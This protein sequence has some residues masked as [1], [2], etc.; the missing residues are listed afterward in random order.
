MKSLVE[1]NKLFV[2]ALIAAM[3]LF[4]VT[5]G[6]AGTTAPPKTKGLDRVNMV[7]DM[8]HFNQLEMGMSYAQLEVI[9]GAPTLFFHYVP[10]ENSDVY[11]WEFKG[12]SGKESYAVILQNDRVISTNYRGKNFDVNYGSDL[13]LDDVVEIAHELQQQSFQGL[14]TVVA[15][16]AQGVPHPP[17]SAFEMIEFDMRYSE[18][19]DML[20]APRMQTCAE[21]CKKYVWNVEDAMISVRFVDGKVKSKKLRTKDFGVSLSLAPTI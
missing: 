18:V 6:F 12:Y 2:G 16:D 7:I 5:T 13:S 1:S 8:D 10:D 9:L 17:K 14:E 3:V 15:R 21:P 11:V 19:T 20:G 4:G